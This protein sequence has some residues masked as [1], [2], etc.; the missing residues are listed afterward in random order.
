MRPRENGAPRPGQALGTGEAVEVGNLG[1][2]SAT[3]CGSR[4]RGKALIVWFAS[5]GLML[6]GLA[7]W[8]IN[9]LGLRGA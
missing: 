2:K 9:K 8:L 5:R 4:H 3:H 6:A 1:A 7:Q